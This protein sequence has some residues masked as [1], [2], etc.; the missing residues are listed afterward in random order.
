MAGDRVKQASFA[1]QML[2]NPEEVPRFLEC[3]VRLQMRIHAH[4]AMQFADLKARLADNIAATK[5]LD[6]RR[7]QDLLDGVADMPG[8]DRLCHGDFHP[9][10]I[11]GEA[12]QAVIIDWP[13]GRRGD[14]AADVCRCY[15]LM[16]L[17][18]VEMAT[19]YLN[20]Y[21]RAASIS[22]Q[23]VLGWLPYIAAARLA[24]GVRGE[25]DGLLKI[26]NTSPLN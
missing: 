10:N 5:F 24:E 13:D 26:V 20:A 23:A 17:H 7:Q 21:C 1:E 22:R 19:T 18:A 2:S 11:L 14:P 3:M 8:G 9:K 16:K 25:L 15:L 12:S 4:G 6:E